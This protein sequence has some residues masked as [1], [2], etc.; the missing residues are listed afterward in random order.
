MKKMVK[1]LMVEKLVKI[2]EKDRIYEAVEKIAEDKETMIACVVDGENR[3]KGII[4][5]REVLKSVE[6]CEYG[7]IRYPFFEGPEVLHL[8]TSKYA[9]DIMG[10]PISVKADDE[11]EKAISIMLDEG[12][13]EVPVVD[14]EGKVIGEINYFGIIISSIEHLKRG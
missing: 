11:I 9:G 12:F 10:P 13:Y 5:P 2:R 4:T 6:V 1:E 14:E 7:T 3:L 8:L